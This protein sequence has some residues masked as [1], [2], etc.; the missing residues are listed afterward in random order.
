MV[1]IPIQSF[2]LISCVYL[3]SPLTISILPDCHHYYLM[4]INANSYPDFSMMTR[5][6]ATWLQSGFVTGPGTQLRVR[7]CAGTGR[8]WHWGLCLRAADTGVCAGT[9]RSSHRCS[10]WG[11][12][13][14]LTRGSAGQSF[15]KA[16]G[17]DICFH[18]VLWEEFSP[19]FGDISDR[20]PAG[21]ALCFPKKDSAISF[22]APIFPHG[23]PHALRAMTYSGNN[24]HRQWRPV[25]KLDEACAPLWFK[26]SVLPHLAQGSAKQSWWMSRPSPWPSPPSS[27]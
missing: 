24:Q 4:I 27:F 18:T 6:G 1:L 25:P 8:S 9:R 5:S 17:D 3:C 13:T 23:W 12:K 16:G 2:V 11:E 19:K 15:F 22:Q 26:I 21:P 7:V 20:K 14:Q 10:V